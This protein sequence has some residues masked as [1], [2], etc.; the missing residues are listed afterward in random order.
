MHHGHLQCIAVIGLNP[1]KPWPEDQHR[2]FIDLLSDACSS[3]LASVL[4]LNE[5]LR[6]ARSLAALNRLKNEELAGL[7]SA[8]TQEL[9]ES[10]NRFER[11][12]SISPAGMFVEKLIASLALTD[13]H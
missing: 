7:L 6:R 3:G 8:R 9:R 13:R 12:A 11:M 1:R 10:E 4:L 5:E 2:V